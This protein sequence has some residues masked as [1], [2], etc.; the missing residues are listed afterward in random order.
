MK[1]IIGIIIFILGSIILF[2][3]ALKLNKANSEEKV[4]TEVGGFSYELE[5]ENEDLGKTSAN[6][7]I[8]LILVGTT[9]FF[10]PKRK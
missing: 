2:Y 8:V 6:I 3:G 9:V 7:G 5:S 1:K 10:F 4:T